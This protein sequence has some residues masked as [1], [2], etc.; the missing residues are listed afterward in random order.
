MWPWADQHGSGRLVD[1]LDAGLA[2]DTLLDHL[3]AGTA[4]EW[5]SISVFAD[6]ADD[7]LPAG[8]PLDELVD[9]DAVPTIRT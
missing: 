3:D 1:V 6:L 4:P 8:M 5:H 7:T 9:L 2:E